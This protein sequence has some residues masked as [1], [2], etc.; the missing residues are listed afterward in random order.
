M[1]VDP[2]LDITLS[3]GRRVVTFQIVALDHDLGTWSV[4]EPLVPR[5]VILG[6]AEALETR[7]RLDARIAARLAAGWV[8]VDGRPSEAAGVPLAPDLTRYLQ[9]LCEAVTGARAQRER[10]LGELAEQAGDV[11]GAIVHYRAALVAW[12][13]SGVRRRLAQTRPGPVGHPVEFAA[14]RVASRRAARRAQ[15]PSNWRV[16]SIA[17]STRGCVDWRRAPASRSGRG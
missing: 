8:P 15:A 1:D 3:N 14:F 12:R 11:T 17:P 16:G 10:R 9:S 6:D 5:R 7:R 4:A 13:G 2:E